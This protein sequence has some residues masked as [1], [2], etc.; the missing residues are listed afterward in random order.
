MT[1]PQ[2]WV[3]LPT[4]P[5]NETD[6]EKI[7]RLEIA[8]ATSLTANAELAKV[9]EELRHQLEEWKRGHRVREH[10]RRSKAA[11]AARAAKAAAAVAAGEPER[12]SGRA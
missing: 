12:R 10:R 6:T 7:A 8:L 1:C 11:K 3:G 4:P 2:Y 9:V 5:A